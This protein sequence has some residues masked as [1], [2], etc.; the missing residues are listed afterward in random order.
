MPAN[1]IARQL[2]TSSPQ[3]A[4]ATFQAMLMMNLVDPSVL[5]QVVASTGQPNPPPAAPQPMYQQPP[6]VAPPPAAYP[7]PQKVRVKYLQY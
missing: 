6:P 7:A 4:Y 1:V 5:Q 3:L 2:L